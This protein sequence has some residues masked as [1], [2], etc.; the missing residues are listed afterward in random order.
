MNTS[1]CNVDMGEL[2]L[3]DA[4]LQNGKI[5]NPHDHDFCSLSR[6]DQNF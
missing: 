2:T 3:T 6:L 5:I 1:L 4:G